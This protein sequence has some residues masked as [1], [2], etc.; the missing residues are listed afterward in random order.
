LATLAP[1]KPVTTIDLSSQGTFAS[2]VTWLND[3]ELLVTLLHGGVAKVSLGS[4]KIT[5]WVPLGE[6]PDGFPYPEL[7]ATDGNLVV[8]MGAGRRNYMFR[9]K[10]GKH[11]SGYGGGRLYP[12]GVAVVDGKAVYMG[13]MGRAGEDETL[14][15]GVL[16][17]QVPGQDVVETPIH[18]I[19]GDN[20]TVQRW[21]MTASPYAGAMVALPDRSVAVMT[22]AEPGIYRFD[23]T[24]KLVEILGSGEDSLMLDTPKIGREYNVD[25]TAR[26][27]QLLNRGPMLDDLVVLPGNGVAALVRTAANGQIGWTLW[28]ADKSGF[29][30][31][32]PLGVTREGPFGHM[33]CESRKSRLACVTDLPG[34]QHKGKPE[35]AGANPRLFLFN[36]PK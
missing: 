2:D 11:L 10:D 19:L 1:L 21:R 6:M 12:R 4:R 18:R 23:H 35:T 13:W 31:K 25:V 30:R 27:V 5:Q 8:V 20:E 17:T 34:M 36:L 26:Y 9:T 33:R 29:S 24:G 3:D 7:V 15:R 28:R 32:Q 22:A 14:R 16:W